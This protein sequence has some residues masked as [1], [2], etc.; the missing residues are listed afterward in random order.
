MSCTDT[1]PLIASPLEQ[2]IIDGCIIHTT[3]AAKGREIWC[4]HTGGWRPMKASSSRSVSQE[5][6]GEEDDEEDELTR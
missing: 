6:A 3:S 1:F 2:T 5:P 4:S